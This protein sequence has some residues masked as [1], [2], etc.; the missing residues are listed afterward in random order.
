MPVGIWCKYWGG[1]NFVQEPKKLMLYRGALYHGHTP[2]GKL[3]EVLHFVVPMFHWVAAMNGCHWDVGHQG[4]QQTLYLLHDRF[5]WP[6]MAAQMQKVI[7]NCKQ[8][9]QHKC[10]CDK[11]AVQTI[12]VTASLELLHIDFTSID[13]NGVGL[14]PKCGEAFG[15]LWPLYETHYGICDPQSNCKN[16]C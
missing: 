10:T 9:I 7:S 1:E 16:Y 4:Q 5:W 2:T 13:N 15:L 6:G 3:E 14:T 12:I 8:C 11:A